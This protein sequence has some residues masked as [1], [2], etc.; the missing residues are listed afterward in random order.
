MAIDFSQVK[1]ISIPEGNVISIS[2][3]GVVIWSAGPQ[4]TSITLS[5]YNTSLSINTTF[6]YG[7]TVTANYSDGSTANVTLDTTFSG[8]NMATAGSQ[9]VT[10]SYTENGI[11]KTATYT[12]TIVS[13]AWHTIWEGTKTIK[14]ASGTIT[15]ASNNFASTA[16]GTGYRPQLRFTFSGMTSG[17]SIGY[18]N[19]GSTS[20]SRP[21]SPMTINQVVDTDNA[22]LLGVY[23]YTWVGDTVRG[24]RAFLKET[25]DSTN[26]NLKFSLA[27][28]NYTGGDGS[29]TAQFTL[30]KIEQYY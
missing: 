8:Y 24:V 13:V 20:S 10:A 18:F 16:T 11:T 19:N 29:Q 25:R 26:N 6:I 4:L 2:S 7:G 1:A 14:N 17:S 5:G 23:K 30:T 12:L 21:S 9:T 22:E 27:G 15:G 3:G 28:T